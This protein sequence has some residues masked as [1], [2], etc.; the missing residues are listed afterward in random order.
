MKVLKFYSETCGSC[1]ILEKNLQL[2]DI[3]HKCID[4]QSMK[5]EAIIAKYNIMAVPTLILIND[6]DE[7]IK[8]H[9]GLLN[10]QELKEFY[11]NIN[12]S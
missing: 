12:N 4:A 8:R 6:K 2:A 7:V 10:V 11:N 9:R 1:K 3:P 5:N